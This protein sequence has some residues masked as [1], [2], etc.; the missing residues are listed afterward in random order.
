[1]NHLRNALLCLFLALLCVLTTQAVYTLERFNE[2]SAAATSAIQE[3]QRR[4]AHTSQNAN[5]VLVQLQEAANQWRLAS[6]NQA[7]YAEQ[8]GAALDETTNMVRE[9]RRTLEVAREQIKANGKASEKAFGE[10]RT[11]AVSIGNS[12]AT[13]LRTVDTSLTALAPSLAHLGA[14]TASL[15]PLTAEAAATA[16]EAH[17]GVTAAANAAESVDHALKPLRTTG[18]RMKAVLKFLLGLVKI[19]IR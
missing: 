19:N 11:Q 9:G 4:V 17:R 5:A 15:A 12:A 6:M 7:K 3:T 1:M 2:A 8:L 14:A 13:S 18:G 10:I 16:R